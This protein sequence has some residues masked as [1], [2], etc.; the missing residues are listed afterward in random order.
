MKQKIVVTGII[1]CNDEFLVVQRSKDDSFFPGAYEF[2]GGKR[3]EK[4]TLLEALKRELKEE[5]GCDINTEEAKLVGYY[6]EVNEEKDVY[7]LELDFLIEVPSKDLDVKL[8]FE[9]EDYKWVTKDSDLLDDFIKSK[10]KN[11]KE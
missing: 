9:H 5:I 7:Y 3:E 10:I 8:S 2:P 4:E 11:I 1:K 6:N